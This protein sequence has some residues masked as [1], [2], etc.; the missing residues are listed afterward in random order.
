MTTLTITLKE[1]L[2]QQIEQFADG[3]GLSLE[4]AAVELLQ[5]TA[6]IR[7]LRALR[8]KGREYVKHAS[9]ES[10]EDIHKAV[11]EWREETPDKA[12]GE[13]A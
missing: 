8:K 3:S 7:R 11:Q 10:K 12:A 4:E 2:E 6:D 5:R 1:D 13:R 9:V